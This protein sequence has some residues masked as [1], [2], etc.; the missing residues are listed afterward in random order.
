ME[1]FRS[2]L[3]RVVGT[4]GLSLLVLGAPLGY[5]ALYGSLY[6]L[7]EER[8]VP[9]AVVHAQESALSRELVRALDAHPS[10]QAVPIASAQEADRA[11]RD[12]KVRAILEF[13]PDLDLRLRRREATSVPLVYVADRFLPASDLQR[14]VSE[15]LFWRGTQERLLI[16]QSRGL[17]PASAR[18]RATAL[19]LDDRPLANPR[20]TYGDFML[21]PLGYL[22]LH[23]LC[24]L[25]IA[26]TTA[27]SVRSRR[28][29]DFA[30]RILLFAPWFG[31]WCV[32]WRVG[33]L[34]LFEVPVQ[35]HLAPLLLLGALA[36]AAVGAM[37]I[38]TG[39]VLRR[40]LVVLQLVAFSSYPFFFSSGASWP[41]EG[42]PPLVSAFSA[43]L[44]ISPWLSATNRAIRLDAGIWDVRAELLQ[45]A[46]QFVGW[47]IVA[48]L[49]ARWT[50]ERS[51]VV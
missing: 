25:S 42:F 19:S 27:A 13:P 44:P 47:G 1:I 8:R 36:L 37:G 38:A 10:L 18:E 50:R 16:L 33:A 6:T 22:I 48:L 31:A 15:V 14:A 41:R 21:P 7:K 35:P 40:P 20:E 39:I 24:F 28:W 45:L 5:L 43:V 3:R 11:L 9:I 30:G 29:K 12:G 34:R 26:F 51:R 4:S 32:L 46:L 49:L 23:Q 2:E 17:A